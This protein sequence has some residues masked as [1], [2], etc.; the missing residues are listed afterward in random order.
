[1]KILMCGGAGYLGGYMTDLLKE[2]NHDVVVY[3]NLLYETRF[4]KNVPF[5]YGDIRDYDKLSKVINDFD[6]V[7]WLAGLVG[8]GACAVNPE[9]TQNINTEPVKWLVDNFKGKI[10]FPSTCSVYGKNDDLLDE[11]SPTNPLSV[12]AAT[13]LEAEQI[14]VKS[15]PESLIFRL[16]TLF[17]TGD[18][19]SRIRLDLVANV[20][21]MK[22]T[23]GETLTVFSG[24]QWRPLLHIRDVAEAVKFGLEHNISGLFNLM[25]KNYLLKDMAE[26]IVSLIPG[27]GVSYSELKFED[28]RNYRV[29]G[30]KFAALGWKPKYALADGVKQIQKLIAEDRIK[31]TADPIYSNAAYIKQLGDF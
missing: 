5:I 30:E 19:H 21:T 22:A 6:V 11:N 16:G 14:L 29:S 12:Y 27:S 10:V 24:N 25:H 3:D 20:L 26:E 15:R 18:E 17:G 28:Q 7:V 31:N 4:V 2:A 8:D 23:R 13:K 9:L 1:M